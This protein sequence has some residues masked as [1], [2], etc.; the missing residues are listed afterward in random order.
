MKTL[1][2]N[3]GTGQEFFQVTTLSLPEVEAGKGRIEVPAWTKFKKI[4]KSL[5][6]CI[7]VSDNWGNKRAVGTKQNFAPNMA[8]KNDAK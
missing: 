5:A 2:K 3:I 8:V 7:D 6:T 1:F 4:S